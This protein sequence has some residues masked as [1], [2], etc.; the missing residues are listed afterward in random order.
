MSDICGYVWPYE[1]DSLNRTHVCGL[2]TGHDGP[3]QA[4]GYHTSYY[5]RDGVWHTGGTTV[6]AEEAK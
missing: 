5:D 1:P 6:L 3:H 2:L 4:I